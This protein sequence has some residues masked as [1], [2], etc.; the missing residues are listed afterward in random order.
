MGGSVVVRLHLAVE[1]G[2]RIVF[3]PSHVCL[4]PPW[5][6]TLL[7]FAGSLPKGLSW[8]SLLCPLFQ[9]SLQ[10]TGLRPSCGGFG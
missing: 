10:I 2:R 6:G 7:F 5:G 9:T 3:A 1:E 4:L 8:T